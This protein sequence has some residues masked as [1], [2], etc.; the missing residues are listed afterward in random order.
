MPFCV[1]L[2]QFILVLLAFVVVSFLQYQAKRL[3]GKN[4]SEM[5]C[6]VWSGA[7]TTLTHSQSHE[8]A[9]LSSR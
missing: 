8:A 4:V 5:T 7:R 6:S 9:M 2:D 3:G 1:S